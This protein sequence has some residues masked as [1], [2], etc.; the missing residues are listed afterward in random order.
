MTYVAT[1]GKLDAAVLAIGLVLLVL[2]AWPAGA[3]LSVC[4]QRTL[5][6]L[7][8]LAQTI[9]LVSAFGVRLNPSV[10]LL[11]DAIMSLPAAI[12]KLTEPRI[13]SAVSALREL[14]RGAPYQT[15]SLIS[16]TAGGLGTYAVFMAG[17]DLLLYY[18]FILS[19][20]SKS[21]YAALA[22]VPLMYGSLL[23]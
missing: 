21:V 10:I 12:A 7:G 19:Q 17:G 13:S 23:M 2:S 8:Y 22:I 14:I 6:V 15:L 5:S 9:K 4:Q 11:I 16:A 20:I 18:N 1:Y 3:Y